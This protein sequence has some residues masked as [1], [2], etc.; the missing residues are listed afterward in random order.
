MSSLFV[1]LK[2]EVPCDDN[3]HIPQIGNVLNLG[4]ILPRSERNI[5]KLLHVLY[6]NKYPIS[7]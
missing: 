1:S 3:K 2:R 4:M 5:I 6:A 7:N